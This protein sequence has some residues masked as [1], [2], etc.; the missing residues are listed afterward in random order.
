M[1]DKSRYETTVRKDNIISIRSR[2]GRKKGPFFVYDAEA[3]CIQTSKIYYICIIDQIQDGRYHGYGYAAFNDGEKIKFTIAS[4][5]NDNI[6]EKCIIAGQSIAKQ[7]G[8]T[9]M[10]GKIDEY[11]QFHRSMDRQFEMHGDTIGA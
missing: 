1:A 2:A 9:L 6:K 4:N 10:T 8:G 3:F 5:N 7:F 11:G